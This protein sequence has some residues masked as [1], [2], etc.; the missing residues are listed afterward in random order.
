MRRSTAVAVEELLSTAGLPPAGRTAR[1]PMMP[2]ANATPTA[3]NAD[4]LVMLPWLI[5]SPN[6]DD[7]IDCA[8]YL[9]S[10]GALV[11]SPLFRDST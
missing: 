7:S 5:V 9:Q 3:V 6:A 4:R 11:K 1:L 2:T 8:M 10:A